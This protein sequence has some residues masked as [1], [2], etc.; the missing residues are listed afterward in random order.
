MQIVVNHLTRMQPGYICVAGLD[1]TTGRHVRPVLEARLSTR[2]L[3]T[4][5]GPFALGAVVDLGS[6]TFV[7]HAPEM[8]D[9]RFNQWK[10]RRVQEFSAGEF[11]RLLQA[12]ARPH[13][14][15]I[16]GGALQQHDTACT[17]DVGDGTASLGCLRVEHPQIA[18][19][20]NDKIR[21]RL[22]DG[23]FQ[24]IVSVADL[25][26]YEP[27]HLTPRR[28]LVE[29]VAQRLADGVAVIL[30]VGL[31]R[32]FLKPGDTASH[33]WLQV[34]NVH[35]ADDPLWWRSEAS[36]RGSGTKPLHWPNPRSSGVGQVG[37]GPSARDFVGARGVIGMGGCNRPRRSS[38]AVE[39]KSV[40]RSRAGPLAAP[41]RTAG[42]VA[43]TWK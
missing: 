35:L 42:G 28:A 12:A 21:M 39:T 8:E 24:A 43:G 29:Q 4:Q 41:G 26:L 7:G 17:V 1:R 30:S 27:D 31:S 18:V 19:D 3:V 32:P 2:L 9:Y 16:F 33:H 5:G 10:A 6:V 11:W 23:Q 40:S 36:V 15:D 25:R 20:A 14:A 38:G 37:H 34:N 22:T 13:L